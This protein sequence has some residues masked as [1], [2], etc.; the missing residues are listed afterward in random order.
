MKYR[1]INIQLALASIALTALISCGKSD[2]NSPGVEYMPDMY[3][4]AA[5]EPYVDYEHPDRMSARQPVK[6]TIP[7][8]ADESEEMYYFPYPYPNTFEGYEEAGKNLI[9][10]IPMTKET[11]AEGKVIFERF[12]I[13]CHGKSGLGDGA[14]PEKSDFPPPPAYNGNTLK[15]L[16]EGKM[17]HTIT[18]GK[19]MMGPHASQL[20]PH[21]RW[22]VIQYV[23]YLQYGESMTK[24]EEETTAQ[25]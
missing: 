19:G 14:V 13:H 9:S 2:P 10:P 12:C 15:N 25:P 16:P 4:S 21:E 7:F 24:P 3:R 11:V 17:Y 23:K 22:L 5:I 1:I 8:T 20:D 6:G 18:Y